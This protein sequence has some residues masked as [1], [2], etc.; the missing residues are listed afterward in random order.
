MCVS[1]PDMPG[2]PLAWDCCGPRWRW[3]TQSPSLGGLVWRRLR[4]WTGAGW[5]S[6]GWY[7]VGS[8]VYQTNCHMKG[9]NHHKFYKKY[10]RKS[11]TAVLFGFIN[12]LMK[13]LQNIAS[14]QLMKFNLTWQST[15][16]LL[17]EQGRHP[18][19]WWG[20]IKNRISGIVK[21][22]TWII[23][24]TLIRTMFRIRVKIRAK[25]RK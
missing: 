21:G 11:A 20:M 5:S 8:R 1:P 12:S 23:I 13:D 14:I 9:W 3:Q 25:I 17:V 22:N 16:S 4:S 6:W 15:T 10:N 7:C 2:P 18:R 24:R 19:P